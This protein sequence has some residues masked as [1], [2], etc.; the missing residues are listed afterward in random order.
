MYQKIFDIKKRLARWS[1][2][3]FNSNK[4]KLPDYY[5]QFIEKKLSGD[6]LTEY[7]NHLKSL[8]WKS[9]YNPNS[10]QTWTKPK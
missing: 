8:G 10:G 1:N 6:K 3:D 7:H 2:N 4:N 5:D 9:V